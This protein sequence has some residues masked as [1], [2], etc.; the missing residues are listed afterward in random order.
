MKERAAFSNLEVN[1]AHLYI[2]YRFYLDFVNIYILKVPPR[3]NEHSMKE[4][5]VFSYFKTP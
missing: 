1:E 4:T 5:P 2:L 3:L